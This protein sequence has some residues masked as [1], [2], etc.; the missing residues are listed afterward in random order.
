MRSSRRP[1]DF[2]P[3]VF[4]THRLNQTDLHDTLPGE[5]GSGPAAPAPPGRSKRA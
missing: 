5:R 1:S 2:L 3:N 4:I